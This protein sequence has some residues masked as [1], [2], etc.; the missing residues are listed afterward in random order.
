MVSI[1]GGGGG[2]G[3]DYVQDPSPQ[4][5]KEG[6]EWYDTGSDS[7]FV[8]DGS[9]WIEQTI[10]THDKLSGVTEGQHRSD[11]RVSDLA[12]IQSVDGQTGDVA[13]AH[14]EPRTYT[15]TTSMGDFT[16]PDGGS[17][18]NSISLPEYHTV[19]R[20]A[21]SFYKDGVTG[22][23]ELNLKK[24]GL[25]GNTTTVD[26]LTNAFGGNYTLSTSI[27]KEILQSVRLEGSNSSSSS[28]DEV[29]EDIE[30]EYDILAASGG[31]N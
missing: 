14:P 6:E 3:F 7:A 15:L 31:A 8:Y 19:T 9:A 18:G 13:I 22:T 30:V 28:Y 25:E 4:D 1:Y 26:T 10:T 2:G 17:G 27:D 5:P 23:I 11:Q 20:L 21:V 16:I 24:T 12:P 29:I